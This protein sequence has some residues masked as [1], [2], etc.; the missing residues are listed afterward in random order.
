MDTDSPRLRP[1]GGVYFLGNCA[2][3]AGDQSGYLGVR[4]LDER[5]VRSHQTCRYRRQK[6]SEPVCRGRF[7]GR[8]STARARLVGAVQRRVIRNYRLRDRVNGWRYRPAG[9]RR[10]FNGE[11]GSKQAQILR[12]IADQLTNPGI[13]DKLGLSEKT[14]RN[15]V[16]AIFT[17]LRVATRAQA[18]AA[19]RHAGSDDRTDSHTG[20]DKRPTYSSPNS[21]HQ[22]RVRPVTQRR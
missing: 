7:P 17:K 3:V 9:G 4:D 8:P 18:I 22:K 6:R 14:I 12:L 20:P 13:A 5:E 11:T 21:Q 1:L 10:A 19:A 16:S 2:G 15:N